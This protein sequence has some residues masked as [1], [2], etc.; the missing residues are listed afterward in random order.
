MA[1]PSAQ[2]VSKLLARGAVAAPIARDQLALDVNLSLL[3]PPATDAD[4]ELLRD[5]APAL[6]WLSLARSAVTDA[7]LAPLASCR[8]LR[9]L[10]LAQTG[11]NDAGLQHLRGLQE[12]RFLNLFG[13]KVTDAGLTQLHNLRQLEKVFLWQTAVTSEGVAALQ[14]A[15]PKLTIDRG[16]YAEEILKV[17][18]ELAAADAKEKKELPDGIVNP[19]C[20]VAGKP[21][22]PA[23]TL[24]HDGRKIAFCCAD[25]R[26]KFSADPGKFAPNLPPNLPPKAESKK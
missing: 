11:I 15:L 10:H 12:L 26:A 23:I 14:A 5:T 3:R 20:P 6:V 25:C 13:T 24:D 1:G 19:K 8:A 21:I 7:G 4:V 2:K 22:D 18:E 9:R 17:A 16:G